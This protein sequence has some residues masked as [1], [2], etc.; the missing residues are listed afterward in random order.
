[1][2]AA[3]PLPVLV[4]EVSATFSRSIGKVFWLDTSLYVS[5]FARVPMYVCVREYARARLFRLAIDVPT[6]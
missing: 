6:F 2:I 4:C 5:V 3:R 1:M